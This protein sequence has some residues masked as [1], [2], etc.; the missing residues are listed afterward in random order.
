MPVIQYSKRDLLRDKV[1]SPSW[2]KVLIESVGEWT[3][4]ADKQSQN[5]AIEST[6]VCNADDGSVEFADVPIG[7]LGTWSFNSKAMGFSLGLVKALAPQF[8]MNAD[9][10]DDKTRIE[11][12]QAEGKMIELFVD[13]NLYEGRMRNKVNHKYRALRS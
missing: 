6:I 4:S 5:L 3:P 12:K 9:E 8:G 2:Y 7:G 10:I 1:V 13:N 11:L